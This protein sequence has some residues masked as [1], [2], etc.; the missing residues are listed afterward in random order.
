M[1]AELKREI[2]P[3]ELGQRELGQIVESVFATMLRLEVQECAERWYPGGTRLTSV[4]HLAGEWNGALLLECDQLQACRFAGR[5]LSQDP[6]ARVD[7]VVRDVLAELANMIGGNMKCLLT[8]KT[9]LSMPSVMDG[10]DYSLRVYGA[11][12]RL[13]LAF[14]CA[15][16]IFWITVLGMRS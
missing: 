1:P 13:R 7:D 9:Q 5:F 10:S 16:G 14:Q 12:V 8:G 4:V 11:E 15:E 2:S 3:S 6:A